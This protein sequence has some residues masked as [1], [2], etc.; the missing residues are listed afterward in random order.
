VSERDH[1]LAVVCAQCSRRFTVLR[2][3][4]G[5]MVVCPLCGA[6]I[7]VPERP[8]AGG[9]AAEGTFSLLKEQLHSHRHCPACEAAVDETD[10]ICVKC[11]YDLAGGR[12]LH[13]HLAEAARPRRGLLRRTV[14][15][16]AL[17]ALAY[18]VYQVLLRFL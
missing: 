4:T 8:E 1:N 15:L 17:A 12:H 6:H 3:L 13:T 7:Q 18:A 16:L 10:R 2:E 5:H 14:T 9:S 11:G